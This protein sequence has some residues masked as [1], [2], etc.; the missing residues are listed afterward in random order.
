MPTAATLSTSHSGESASFLLLFY[1]CAH[2]DWT[3]RGH[4]SF[5]PLLSSYRGHLE[6][7]QP[8]GGGIHAPL[9]KFQPMSQEEMG[10]IPKINPSLFLPLM[11]YCK[12]MFP[13]S[14]SGRCLIWPNNCLF[15]YIYIFL[16]RCGQIN[17]V[18]SCTCF[19]SF[20]WITF[21]SCSLSSPLN[22]TT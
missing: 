15:L 16:W 13:Q 5:L 2:S 3:H 6:E 19:C 21:L 18:P 22:C 11:G 1:L 8:T 9:G 7:S 4:G 14:L 10:K 12:T 20:P 17:I